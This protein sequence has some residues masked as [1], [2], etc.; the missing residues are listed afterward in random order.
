MADL[1]T[2]KFIRKG[3]KDIYHKLIKE[4]HAKVLSNTK[5]QRKAIFKALTLLLLYWSFYAL[6]LFFGNHTVA[7][8]SLYILM[9]CTMII[10]F[11]NSFHDAAHNAVFKTP[12]ANRRFAYILE[13][14]GTSSHLW[15]QRHI[16]LHH[17]YPNIPHWDADIKQ[18]N[19][20]RLFPNVKWYTFNRYQHIYVWLL[21]PFYTLIWL[22]YRDF[23]DFFGSKDNYIKRVHKIPRIEYFKLFLAKFLNLFLFLGLP[24]LVLHHPF[25][26]ILTAWF[27]MHIVSS[28][29]GVVALISTHVDE[30]AVFPIPGPDGQMNTTWMEHQMTVTKDFSAGHPVADF[31]YGG[32]TH[33][34]AHHLFP[35]ISHVYYPKITPIIV[36]FAKE[37]D[38]PYTCYP[39]W[40]AIQSHYKLLKTRGSKVNI[41]YNGEL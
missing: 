38:L 4:V 27:L 23:K 2:P 29:V 40:S 24:Y 26:I 13:F 16:L 31:L 8:F 18:S 3:K 11:V 25:S 39:V 7:L 28:I 30:D 9:G 21:Y 20:V 32:F 41:F 5:I 12:E 34:V 6:L 33:H 17:P 19:L 36:A 10:L 15:I 22:Y 37:H 1:H 35:G 14:F